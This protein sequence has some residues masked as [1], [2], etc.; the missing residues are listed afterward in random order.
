MWLTIH[1]R[2]ITSMYL[3][4]NIHENCGAYYKYTGAT[5]VLQNCRKF[6]NSKGDLQCA[7]G[8]CHCIF[9]VIETVHGLLQFTKSAK[10]KKKGNFLC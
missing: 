8:L 2:H 6:V 9:S 10:H 5:F 7:I 3:Y 1:G 4:Q